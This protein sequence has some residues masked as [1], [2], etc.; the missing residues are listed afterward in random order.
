MSTLTL[1][2]A[3]ETLEQKIQEQTVE[4]KR[5]RTEVKDL[6][7]ER[8]ELLEY[9]HE[10]EKTTR[11]NPLPPVP[12]PLASSL[13]SKSD[14]MYHLES[15]N[16]ELRRQVMDLQILLNRNEKQTKSFTRNCATQTEKQ[17]EEEEQDQVANLG[18]RLRL[19][20][21]LLPRR[22]V[23]SVASLVRKS[24]L[25]VVVDTRPLVIHQSSQ[26]DESL[27]LP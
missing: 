22:E 18:L 21:V 16:K 5:L 23:E 19:P 1:E 7:Q 11:V 6:V 12:R 27:L 10:K 15:M 25:P 20:T 4:I 9:I 17:E 13:P 26:T 14:E 24:A 8:S 2:A 3:I